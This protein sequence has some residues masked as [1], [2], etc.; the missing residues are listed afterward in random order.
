MATTDQ[1]TFI[2]DLILAK[3]RTFADFKKWLAKTGIV[4]TNGQIFSQ[5]LDLPSIMNRVTTAQA[6]AIIEAMQQLDD[7]KYKSA[8]DPEQIQ[9][10]STILAGIDQEVN[11]WTF[12]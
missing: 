5:S 7:V 12:I 11:S 3:H 6:T 2:K 10:V 9:K 8:Y 1:A 4:R